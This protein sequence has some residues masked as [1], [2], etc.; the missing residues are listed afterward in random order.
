MLRLSGDQ[1]GKWAPS[2]PSSRRGAVAS[3]ERTQSCDVV[4]DPE[5]PTT[6][7]TVRP[8]GEI[9]TSAESG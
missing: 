6:N 7:A 3:S 4:S 8:S 9:A 5:L 1:N 2:P